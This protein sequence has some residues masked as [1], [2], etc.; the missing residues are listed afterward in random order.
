MNMRL[1]LLLALTC[2]AAAARAESGLTGEYFN[3]IDLT[4]P[5]ATRVDAVLDFNWGRGRPFKEITGWDTAYAGG[6][7]FSARWTGFLAV[8]ATGAYTIWLLSDD[9]ARMWVDGKQVYNRWADR[10]GHG[11]NEDA[12][13]PMNL[14]AGQF[15]PIKIEYFQ[16]HVNAAIRLSW[17]GPDG[18]KVVVPTEC[19]STDVR[20]AGKPAV[21][22]APGTTP[23]AP[24]KL[25]IK[26]AVSAPAAEVVA[27]WDKKLAKRTREV[28]AAGHHPQFQVKA[29]HATLTVQSVNEAGDLAVA[30]AEGGEMELTWARLAREDLRNL[31]V[32][33]AKE[34]TPED[35]ALAAF[36][37]LLDG[38]AERAKEHLGQA[39]ELGAGVSKEFGIQK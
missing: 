4:K 12:L 14:A 26:A 13:A 10:W 17:V 18:K 24:A 7:Q 28:A 39:K 33:L 38:D 11:T 9:G 29:L 22:N 30:L 19:L 32:A 36:Y 23:S 8:P 1:G 25:I 27:A 5:I 2:F 34:D 20:G 3:S 35:H 37:L 6:Y 16:S 21:T 31:A 15:Y